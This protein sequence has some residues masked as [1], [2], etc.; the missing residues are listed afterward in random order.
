VHI[1]KQNV[2]LAAQIN[3]VMHKNARLYNYEKM[4]YFVSCSV[5]Q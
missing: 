1:S 2:N 5:V 3:N 4:L